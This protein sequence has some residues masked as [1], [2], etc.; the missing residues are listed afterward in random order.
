VDGVNAGEACEVPCI[1]GEN[2]FYAVDVHGGSEPGIMNLRAGD[3]VINE[4]PTP[5]VVNCEGVWE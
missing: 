5:F 4:Q 2:A 3:A 1:E